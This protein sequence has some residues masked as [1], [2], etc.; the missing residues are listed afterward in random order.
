[1]GLGRFAYLGFALLHH[2]RLNF[3]GLG[4]G[5]D[6]ARLRR[7]RLHRRLFG[8]RRLL[9]VPRLRLDVALH[10]RLRLR[11]R[12]EAV[13]RAHRPRSNHAGTGEITGT[14][15]RRHGRTALVFAD[16]K[17][18]VGTRHL[19]MLA[20]HRRHVDVPLS[21]GGQFVRGRPC[22]YAIAAVVADPIHR[23]VVD[24]GPVVHIRDARVA[25]VV[26]GAVVK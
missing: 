16:A 3:A 12:A 2:P 5:W 7:V 26:D 22:L 17:G 19:F 11:V 15:S 14:R 10:L 1:L 9:A 23:D 18:G 13:R 20:L 25:D 6:R 4:R 24:D 21:G 8:A